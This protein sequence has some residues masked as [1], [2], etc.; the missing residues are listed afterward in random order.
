[1]RA[2]RN[3]EHAGQVVVQRTTVIIRIGDAVFVLA[4]IMMGVMMVHVRDRSNIGA[5]S[6]YWG[7]AK[8]FAIAPMLQ[9]LALLRI[10]FRRAPVR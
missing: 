10:R 5:A 6:G 7:T 1:V 8:Q 2:A 4:T 9:R 3:R